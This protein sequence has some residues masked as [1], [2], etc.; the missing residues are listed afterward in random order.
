MSLS[1]IAGQLRAMFR[2]RQMDAEM[3]DEIQA[4]LEAQ[5][6]ENERRGL[7]PDEARY[8]AQR[9]FGGVEQIKERV[10]D[11][12]GGR[13]L[14]DLR[15]DIHFGLRMVAKAPGISAVIVLSLALG[16]GANTGVFSWIHTV[17]LEPL[18]GVRDGRE[19]V[20]LEQH[21]AG[22]LIQFASAAEWRDL[23]D[24]TKAFTAVAAQNITTFGFEGKTATERVWGEFVT[25]NF[26]STLGVQ[27]VLGRVLQPKD[28]E[29]GR[30]LVVVISHKF[31]ETQFGA[32]PDAIGRTVRLND[33][34]FTVVGV[35]PADFQGGVS[36][37]TFDL[38]LPQGTS[39]NQED[40]H[41]R[42]F[43]LLG[44]LRPG[45]SLRQANADVA[46]VLARLEKMFPDANR[47]LAADVIPLWRS[48]VGAQALLVPTLATLQTV[49]VLLLLV[50]CTNT[51]NLLL[52]QGTTRQKEIAIRLSLGA[53]RSRVVRQLLTESLVLALLAAGLGTLLS[54]WALDLINQVP[55]PTGMPVAIAA[56]L[57]R[58]E[59]VF[60]IGLAVVCAVVFGLAP[61]LQTTG[62]D[63]AGALKVGGRT[64]GGL[65]RRRLQEVLV[66]AEI[67]LTLV[68]VILAGMFL[69]SFEHAR[70]VDPGFEPRRVLLGS[71]DLVARGYDQSRTRE[72]PA[73]LLDRV[74]ALPGV[75]AATVATWVP[76][77]LVFTQPEEFQLEGRPRDGELPDHTL[78]YETT[79]G[80]FDTLRIKLVEGRDLAAKIEDPRDAEAVV[81][82]EFVRR[83]LAPGQSALG[84]HLSLSG[85]KTAEREYGYRIVGVVRTGKYNTLSEA[86]QP[87]V[88]L[89]FSGRWRSRVTLFVRTAAEPAEMYAA[90]KQTLHDLDPSLPLLEN[91]TLVQ[92]L[93]NAMVLRV[94]PAKILGVLGPLSLLL[95]AIGLY[96]VLAY[97]VAQRTHEIGVRMT[98]G[99]SARGVVLLIMR[100]GMRAVAGG[101]LI[102][103]ALAY[104]ASV[105]LSHELVQVSAGDPELF[106]TL[107]LLL[108]GV[109]W[110]ACWLPAR[111]A[112]KIDPM[113]ALRCE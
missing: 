66:G 65:G 76:L 3:A 73:A 15:R 31:W 100:Q 105:R 25:G 101:V 21:T 64:S 56:H 13:W 111:H 74:R 41:G 38:W 32:R 99:A 18:P 63:V 54:F 67:A 7:P 62:G 108:A 48:R 30:P 16:L 80:Y 68:I 28:D 82:E 92:H 91:R 51:A 45:V 61:A 55:K 35:A 59:L 94:I 81:N 112:A 27:P 70:Q 113:V 71:F 95:A 77:D 26:F 98:L 2:R 96:S 42:Y 110:F 109:A 20:L 34:S 9:A 10:R 43:Q 29:A 90:V 49:M 8:A 37:L 83:Y 103:V 1:H 69:K 86:P 72:F 84:R 44:R 88:Y 87:M 75:E 97:A 33:R 17:A 14:D 40:R 78:C 46:L 19:L 102:G 47:G 11:Q 106:L 85:R 36:A 58:P 24:Q 79:S 89:S 104:V 52:A 5:A 39:W 6:A 60:S 4:H 53:G 23:R 107:P 12:R 22:G 93:D 50:V 57:E